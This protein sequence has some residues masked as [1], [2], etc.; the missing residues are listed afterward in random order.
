VN[1]VIAPDGGQIP[2]A[3]NDHYPKL[4][5][6]K[7]GSRGKSHRAAVG[8]VKG[9]GGE[10]GARNPATTAYPRNEQH[11]LHAPAKLINGPKDGP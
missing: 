3:S 4:R 5:I 10:M 9:I 2:I 8:G 6:E 7:L 1:E 11:L